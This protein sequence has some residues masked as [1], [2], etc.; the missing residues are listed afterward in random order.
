MDLREYVYKYITI[1]Q[2]ESDTKTMKFDVLANSSQE[3]IGIIKWHGAWRQYAFYP[4]P[5]TLFSIECMEVINFF[6][7]NLNHERRN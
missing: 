3:K 5:N 1:K 4:E 6:M 7:D 2:I